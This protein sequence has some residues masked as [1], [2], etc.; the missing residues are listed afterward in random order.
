MKEVEQPA[1]ALVASDHASSRRANVILALVVFLSTAYFYQAS[2]WNQNSRVDLVRAL[3]E[4]RGVRID[5]FHHNTGDKAFAGGHYYSDKAPGAAF[6]AIPAVLLARVVLWIV[7]SDINSTAGLDAQLYAAGLVTGSLANTITALMIA[8]FVVHFGG[9]RLGGS[10]AGLLFALGTPAWAYGTLFMGHA[11][12]TSCLLGGLALVCSW[13]RSAPPVRLLASGFLLAWTVVVEYP[14]AVPAVAVFAF[15]AARLVSAHGLSRALIRPAAWFACGGALPTLILGGYH[16]AAFGGP[17]E[18]G[19]ASI[20]PLHAGM[21]LG[22]FGLTYPK[23]DVL[24]QLLVHPHRGLFLYSPALLAGIVGLLRS[25][26]KPSLRAEIWLF[27]LIPVYYLLMN[28]SYVYWDG[29]WCY[30]PRHLAPALAFLAVGAGLFWSGSG[31]RVRWALC[32][33]FAVGFCTAGV[34]VATNAQPTSEFVS[35]V[36]DYSWPAFASG[37]L[38]L[39]PHPV[40]YNV[41]RVGIPTVP[42]AWNLGELFGLSGHTSLLPLIYLWLSAWVAWPRERHL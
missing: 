35:P 18:L 12:T 11:L 9:S 34:V 6:T 30:G 21:G 17:F 16:W 19:Y 7:D 42:V 14:S 26:G 13:Q 40:E 10:F 15:G 37:Q 24:F 32:G 8:W 22:L 39:N 38:S 3:I 33:L 28:A 25:F 5:A 41:E 20:V 36:A 27:R 4:T 23:P 2:G 31:Q 1:A 29:G